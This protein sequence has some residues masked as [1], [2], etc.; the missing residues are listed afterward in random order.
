MVRIRPA[1]LT[2]VAQ[3]AGVSVATASR[4]LNGSPHRV[5]DQLSQRVHDAARQLNY[6]PNVGAQVLARSTSS[7]VAILV[8]DVTEHYCACVLAGVL[9]TA[10]DRDLHVLVVPCQIDD[11]DIDLTSLRGYRPRAIVVAFSQP[12]TSEAATRLH[13]QLR[14]LQQLGCDVVSIGDEGMTEKTLF[15]RRQPGI[16]L[17]QKPLVQLG[18]EALETALQGLLLR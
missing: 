6:A 7:T 17:E 12:P 11:R 9:I 3:A 5:S 8:D 14:A 10:E 16:S 18:S 13:G 2:D 4:V 1:R 15:S